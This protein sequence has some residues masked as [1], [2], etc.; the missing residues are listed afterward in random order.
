MI[1]FNRLTKVFICREATDMRAS[2]DTLFAKV[3]GVLNQDPYTGHL[4]VFINS[5]RN[6]IKCLFWDGT[7]LVLLCKRIN[8]GLFHKINPL[9]KGE[10]ILSPAEFALFFEGADFG[11]RFIES[12][13]EIKKTF[14]M[15]QQLQE[16]S[17]SVIL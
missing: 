2:Y 5:R 3:K 9:Y 15:R 1:S 12:P 7:G 8:E 14:P 13:R 11:K 16:S 17:P 10:V 6:C 4:F